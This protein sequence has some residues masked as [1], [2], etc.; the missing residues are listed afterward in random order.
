MCQNVK[1]LY[2]MGKKGLDRCANL[3]DL[4]NPGAAQRSRVRIQF[5][6]KQQRKAAI[7][8]PRIRTMRGLM[9]GYYPNVIC[10]LLEK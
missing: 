7:P 2:K 5:G 4:D 9:F 8:S 10:L 3:E 1:N 6:R